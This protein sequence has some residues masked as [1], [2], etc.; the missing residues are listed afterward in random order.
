[1]SFVPGKHPR[2]QALWG[3]APCDPQS[4]ANDRHGPA[5]LPGRTPAAQHPQSALQGGGPAPT[6]PDT[7]ERSPD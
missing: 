6:F 7:G 4:W 3:E 5:T 2:A 1:M